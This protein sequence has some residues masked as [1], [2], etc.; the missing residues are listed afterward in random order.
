MGGIKNARLDGSSEKIQ[1][2][3][4]VRGI[5]DRRM[6]ARYKGNSGASENIYRGWSTSQLERL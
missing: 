2:N 1:Q 6:F 3:E 5:Q 4:T